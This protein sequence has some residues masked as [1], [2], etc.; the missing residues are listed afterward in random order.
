MA[1]QTYVNGQ[2]GAS[3]GS[4]LAAAVVNNTIAVLLLTGFAL[5]TGGLARALRRLRD[6]DRGGRLRPW[7]LLA[8]VN[9]GLFLAAG[10]EAAV[11]IGVAVFSVALIFGQLFG[12]LI[13]DRFGISP[14]GVRPVTAPR[15]VGVALGLAAVTIAGAG[16]GGELQPWLIA[17]TIAIG[18]ATGIQQAAMGHVTAATGEPAV[19][20]SI[21]A[22]AGIAVVVAIELAISASGGLPALD[23]GAT[24]PPEWLGGVLAALILATMATVV[25]Q[26]GLLVLALALVT[27]QAAGSLAVD[28]VAPAGTAVTAATVA[29]VVLTVAA[30]AVT[31]AG[32]RAPRRARPAQTG[33]E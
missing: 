17:A 25:R 15:L 19:A 13:S 6:P 20:A 24:A 12:G 32:S 22:C 23:P 4:P 30:M 10:A 18:G 7:H 14:A 8:G 28:L 21:N 3:L 26:L 29:G 9:G 31:V 33:A 2:L 1:L 16:S 27:G 11:T 5:A